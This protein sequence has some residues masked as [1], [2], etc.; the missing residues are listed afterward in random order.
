[1]PYNDY[2]KSFL[3][4]A[5]A[6][7]LLA[8][9][10]PLLALLGM[11]LLLTQGK[12]IFFIQKRSGKALRP[13]N[14]YKFRTL[15]HD[16]GGSLSM[17]NRQFTPLGKLMRATSLDEL[18]QLVNVL[19]GDMSL[20]GPRPMPVEYEG[21]YSTGQRKRFEVKPGIT[22]WAQVNGRNATSWERRF[23]LDAEYARKVSFFFDLKILLMTIIQTFNTLS[24]SRKNHEE[25]PVFR[26]TNILAR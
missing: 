11:L 22:G 5:L 1:M 3:D 26:G 16:D 13:F 4:R 18:P 2:I 20:V 25:M 14:M 6:L 23:R 21:R 10:L 12:G 8:A 9:L 15:T 19:K 7:T 24:K 17:E